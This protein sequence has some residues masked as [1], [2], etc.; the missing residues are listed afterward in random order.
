M[1]WGHEDILQWL[2]GPPVFVEVLRPARLG[3]G[4]LAPSPADLEQYARA[5]QRVAAGGEVTHFI[6][7]SGAASRMRASLNEQALAD[8]PELAAVLAGP[9]GEQLPKALIPVHRYATGTR[10]VLEEQCREAALIAGEEGRAHCLHLTASVSMQSML[11]AE[12]RRTVATLD[13]AGAWHVEVTCQDPATNM[14]SLRL[15]GQP[16]RDASGALHLRA[17]GHGALLGNLTQVQTTYAMVKNIDN[18]VVDRLRPRVLHHRRALLGILVA[19]R[20]EARQAR[21]GGRPEMERWCTRWL[22]HVPGEAVDVLQRPM[23][24]CGMVPNDGAPGGGPFWTRRGLQI[25]EGSEID[26]DDAQQQAQMVASTHFNP[27]DMALCL[28]DLDGRRCDLQAMVDP[29][30]RIRV[31]RQVLG[32][33]AQTAELPGLWN[34]SMSGWNTVFVAMPAESFAPIKTISDLYA[35]PHQP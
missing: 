23:R 11:D 28:H 10:T 27:V 7:A 22:G 6:P 16:V 13:F 33:L 9:A 1:G 32:E 14:P 3:D 15:D 30:R 4:I 26:P 19:M 8:F 24:V 21:S 31:R 25:V 12:A 34:G 29:S 20:E 18:V 2:A 5:G 17:G 35:A